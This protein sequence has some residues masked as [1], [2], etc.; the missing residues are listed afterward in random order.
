[1]QANSPDFAAAIVAAEIPKKVV[2]SKGR[3]V[4]SQA[5]KRL[6]HF[7]AGFSS[8]SCTLPVGSGE[9]IGIADRLCMDP[10]TVHLAIHAAV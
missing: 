8:K 1:M 2:N 6:L 5:I 7:V 9:V 3:P 10:R 4:S